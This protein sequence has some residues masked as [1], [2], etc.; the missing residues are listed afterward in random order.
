MR[1]PVISTCSGSCIPACAVIG[2]ACAVMTCPSDRN[3]AVCSNAPY[4]SARLLDEFMMV[5]LAQ[6]RVSA[7]QTVG[8]DVSSG[9]LWS[10]AGIARKNAQP[11]ELKPLA[12]SPPNL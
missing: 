7:V 8:P 9:S 3:D 10:Y 1:D 12:H 4:L 11:H 6:L 5:P 2:C